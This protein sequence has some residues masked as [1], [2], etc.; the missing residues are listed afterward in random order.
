MNPRSF[1]ITNFESFYEEVLKQKEWA[2]RSKELS[3]VDKESTPVARIQQKLKAILEEQ[4]LS[5]T[6]Q[7]GEFA[8]S[9]Y[10]EAQYIMVALADEVFLNLSWFGA[11]TWEDNLLEGQIFY[12]EI[13]G[14]LFFSKLDNLL[15]NADPSNKDLA[16][17]YLM[18]L[19]LG[20][21]GKYHEQDDFGELSRYRK[22]LYSL[23]Y[24]QQ[25]TLMQGRDYLL[26][27]PYQYTLSAIPKQL[28]PEIRFW[29]FVFVATVVAYVF[30]T[31][32]LWY[33]LAKDLDQAMS[34]IL[35]YAPN[36]P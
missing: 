4:F 18:A 21:R 27:E 11:K 26:P 22:S 35:Q 29:G 15:K 33:Q 31:Y 5:S 23:V 32:V 13:A 8:H 28:L 12:T 1:L 17:I 16:M 24:E 30:I 3:D 9:R 36:M 14:E 10:Q 25:A 19:G 7:S 6:R 34:F 2:L 20:F